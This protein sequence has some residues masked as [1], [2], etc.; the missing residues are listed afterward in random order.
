MR[1][2]VGLLGNS[3]IYKLTPS[4]LIPLTCL[5]LSVDAVRVLRTKGKRQGYL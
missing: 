4:L 2:I 1:L 3:E 5:F